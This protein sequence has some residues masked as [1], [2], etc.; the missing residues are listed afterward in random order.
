MFDEK[1]RLTPT[2]RQTM[3][4]LQDGWTLEETHDGS[5]SYY[6]FY[7]LEGTSPEAFA[8]VLKSARRPVNDFI[9][10]M[11]EQRLIE[12]SGRYFFLTPQGEEALKSY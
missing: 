12:K 7:K 10:R 1:I 11:L 9:Y 3:E 8:K 4:A 2:Q 5:T 6:A